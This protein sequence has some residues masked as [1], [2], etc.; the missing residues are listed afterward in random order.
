V[1]RVS[2]QAMLD[3]PLGAAPE[4]V[5]LPRAAF[6]SRRKDA[7]ATVRVALTPRQ[8]RWL[9]RTTTAGGIDADA[10]IRA[11]VDVVMALDIDWTTV[12]SA[13]DL[14]RALESAIRIRQ[15]P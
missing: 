10:T 9:D 4:F 2:Y 15:A 11:A 1:S 14:R 13:G 5:P 8:R 7:S 6:V 3:A 12:T